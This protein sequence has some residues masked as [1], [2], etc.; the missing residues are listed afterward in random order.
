MSTPTPVVPATAVPVA[1]VDHWYSLQAIKAD[2][3]WL[4]S[5]LGF[6]AKYAPEAGAVADAV[7]VGVGQPELIV[8]TS[9]A[10][11]AVEA[12]EA[13]DVAAHSGNVQAAL[14]SVQAVINDTKVIVT[15]A[16]AATTPAAP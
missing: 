14:Q 13:A 1:T 5:K 6:L 16:V 2:I 4:E 3:A 11:G 8:A 12:A 7:E 9:A 10:V 15:G